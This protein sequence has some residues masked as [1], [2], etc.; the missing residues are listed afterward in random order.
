MHLFEALTPDE[1][2]MLL[3]IGFVTLLACVGV[4]IWLVVT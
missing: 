1:G 3:L 4:A 2:L